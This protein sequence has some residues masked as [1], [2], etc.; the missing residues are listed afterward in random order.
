MLSISQPH[1]A[2]SSSPSQQVK[3][4]INVTLTFPA[5]VTSVTS[6]PGKP[7]F[8]SSTSIPTTTI[9]TAITTN[10]AITITN[11]SQTLLPW[12]TTNILIT[13]QSTISQAFTTVYHILSQASTKSSNDPN[14]EFKSRIQTRTRLS[15]SNSLCIQPNDHSY[16]NKD[17]S[18]YTTINT[19]TIPLTPENDLDIG[20]ANV[21]SCQTDYINPSEYGPFEW[22]HRVPHLH[23]PIP[24]YQM[25]VIEK[26]TINPNIENRHF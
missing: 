10:A 9:F 15:L 6:L 1:F 4:P 14:H 17:Q 24:Y 7:L 3:S 8:A 2:D 22:L 13:T 26:S 16:S 21:K 11:S 25:S 19:S 23:D 12:P 20:S 18:I 5:T